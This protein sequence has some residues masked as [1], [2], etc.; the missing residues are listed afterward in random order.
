MPPEMQTE[1][2]AVIDKNGKKVLAEARYEGKPGEWKLCYRAG[3]EAT[4]A[5]RTAAPGWLQELPAP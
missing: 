1:M 3:Q 4:T 5:A 2:K